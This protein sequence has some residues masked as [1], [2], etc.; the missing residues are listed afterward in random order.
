MRKSAYADSTAVVAVHQRR[1]AC[2]RPGRPRLL[3][4][5][6]VVAILLDASTANPSRCNR[7]AVMTEPLDYSSRNAFRPHHRSNAATT[8]GDPA[9]DDSS[10]RTTNG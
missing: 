8:T 9:R 10:Q 1:A 3:L 6:A 5:G 7:R 4:V 2:A